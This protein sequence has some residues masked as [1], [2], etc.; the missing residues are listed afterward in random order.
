[1]AFAC[2]ATC[3]AACAHSDRP[4]AIDPAAP[5]EIRV[6]LPEPPAEVAACLKRSF[7]EIPDRALTTGDVVRIV[8]RAKV[9]DRTKTACGLRAIAWIEAVRR[10]FAKP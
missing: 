4:P 1:M 8:G 2:L 6:P 5:A 3:L 9:L 10:D 7:P